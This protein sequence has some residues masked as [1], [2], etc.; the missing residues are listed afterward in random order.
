MQVQFNFSLLFYHNFSICYQKNIPTQKF[1]YQQNIRY[2]SQMGTNVFISYPFIVVIL[3]IDIYSFTVL[4]DANALLIKI[5]KY[6]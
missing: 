2:Y 5:T 3:S 1:D 6:E 4:S